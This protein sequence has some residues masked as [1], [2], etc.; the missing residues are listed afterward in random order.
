MVH[1]SGIRPQ[2]HQGHRQKRER[3]DVVVIEY[4]TRKGELTKIN[5][6]VSDLAKLDLADPLER[7]TSNKRLFFM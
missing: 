3:R 6:E 1:D 5:F 4:A 2:W 7:F